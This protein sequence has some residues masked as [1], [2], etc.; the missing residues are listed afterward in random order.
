MDA[1]LTG[2]PKHLIEVCRENLISMCGLV[3]AALV[4]QTLINLGE[5]FS[6]EEV[7]YDNS[8]SQGGDPNRVVGYA[9]VVFVAK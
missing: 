4:M 8:A 7:A 1:M 5:L 2:D 9:G 6:V 3:P